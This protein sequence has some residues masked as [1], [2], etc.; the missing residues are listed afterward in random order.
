MLWHVPRRNLQRGRPPAATKPS[1]LTEGGNDNA[2]ARWKHDVQPRRSRSSADTG[3]GP[4]GEKPAAPGSHRIPEPAHG[5]TGLRSRAHPYGAGVR[6]D[7][8]SSAVGERTAGPRQMVCNHHPPYSHVV[9]DPGWCSKEVA[10]QGRRTRPEGGRHSA[11]RRPVDV[12][13]GRGRRRSRQPGQ[14]APTGRERSLTPFGTP[15]MFDAD[16]TAGPGQAPLNVGRDRSASIITGS[17]AGQA[18]RYAPARF[19]V[20]GRARRFLPRW[21]WQRG[22]AAL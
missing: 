21:S 7:R 8:R 10:E 16:G 3:L 2:S 9:V 14:R 6:S 22:P 20:Q 15:P 5:W 13:Q 18:P 17:V 19:G 12:E 4:L 11:T 1:W